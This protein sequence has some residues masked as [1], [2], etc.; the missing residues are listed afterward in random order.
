VGGGTFARYSSLGELS[1]SK[2]DGKVK[3]LETIPKVIERE[4]LGAGLGRSGGAAGFGGVATSESL[5]KHSI[6]SDTQ[7]NFVV[8]E[9]GLPG[10]ILYVGLTLRLITLGLTGLKRIADVELRIYLAAMLATIVG[11]TLMGLAGPTMASSAYGPFFWFA[12][13]TFGYWF[14]TRRRKPASALTAPI[15]PTAA[16][17]GT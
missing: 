11:F 2:N 17:V 6:S 7:Y 16:P 1:S 9:L 10:L 13:G 12:A 14:I 3:S 5:E 4:P 15:T 8:D